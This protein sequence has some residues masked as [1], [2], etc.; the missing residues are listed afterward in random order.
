[1][2]MLQGVTIDHVD[3]MPICDFLKSSR[4]NPTAWSWPG[5]RPARSRRRRAWNARGAD[6]RRF[7][8]RRLFGW[9]F[10][11]G[12][13]KERGGR[14]ERDG[15]L[16]KGVEGKCSV[17][18]SQF[19]VTAAR[20][21]RLSTEHW[22]CCGGAAGWPGGHYFSSTQ[23][24]G[25]LCP[26]PLRGRG[27]AGVFLSEGQRGGQIAVLG[28]CRKKAGDCRSS[29]LPKRKPPVCSTARSIFAGPTASAT[30]ASGPVPSTATMLRR[31]GAAFSCGGWKL[32]TA[33]MSWTRWAN[34][35][36]L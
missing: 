33:Q 3:A 7:W 27:G 4:A 34:T 15:A 32:S 19:S 30:A 29:T 22:E 17:L 2:C 16:G 28:R 31:R 18:S 20:L 9:G 13:H 36:G 11:S 23:P 12:A 5:W 26:H 25:R 21:L 8:K 35:A 1:M 6:W 24:I 10:G 14:V